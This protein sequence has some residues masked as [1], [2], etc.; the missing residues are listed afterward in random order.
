VPVFF[1]RALNQ[2][3][4]TGRDIRRYR[5]QDWNHDPNPPPENIVVSE[6]IGPRLACDEVAQPELEEQNQCDP[7]GA[8]QR[9]LV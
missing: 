7:D 5:R 9:G 3:T 1:P 2:L 6:E 8:D 4:D